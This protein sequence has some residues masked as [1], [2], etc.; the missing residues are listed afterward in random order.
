MTSIHSSLLLTP[1]V[2]LRIHENNQQTISEKRDLK[3][4]GVQERL[5]PVQS[6]H[7]V[8]GCSFVMHFHRGFFLASDLDESFKVKAC[9]AALPWVASGEARAS[10]GELQK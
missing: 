8:L 2:L 6:T 3:A 4:V 9:R 1:P 5:V 10:L 7:A